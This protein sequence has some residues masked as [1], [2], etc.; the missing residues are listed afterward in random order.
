MIVAIGRLESAIDERKSAR[1]S[2]GSPSVVAM[3]LDAVEVFVK[4]R[5]RIK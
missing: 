4:C 2:G 5:A 3:V 1:G